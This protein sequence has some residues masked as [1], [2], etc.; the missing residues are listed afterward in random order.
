[1]SLYYFGKSRPAVTNPFR[2]HSQFL[3]PLT[4]VVTDN[5]IV[6]HHQHR[7]AGQLTVVNFFL[8][9]FEIN[10]YDKFAA[11]PVFAFHLDCAAHLFRNFFTD[12]EPQSG[13][14]DRLDFHIFRPFKRVE[15]MA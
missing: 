10:R 11:L 9:Y 3:Q 4:G 13:A 6:I 5:Y 14:L 7:Q 8:L 1:M 2:Y 12:R 15:H